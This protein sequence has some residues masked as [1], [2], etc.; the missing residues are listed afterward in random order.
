MKKHNKA[1]LIFLAPF[2]FLILVFVLQA[3]LSFSLQASYS[4]TLPS[5]P[6]VTEDISTDSVFQPASPTDVYTFDPA[7]SNATSA[8][9]A[10][11]IFRVILAFLGL[12]GVLGIFVSI[13][14]G[15]FVL[16]KDDK[17]KT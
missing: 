17:P 3:I 8:S 5:E 6:I 10:G 13:P 11:M 14:F 15:I 1:A 12:I 16:I 9:T 2:V 4:S 7:P